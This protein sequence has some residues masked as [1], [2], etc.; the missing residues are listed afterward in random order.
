M[1]DPAY[2]VTGET[3]ITTVDQYTKAERLR[4]DSVF[5]ATCRKGSTSMPLSQVLS[6]AKK[7]EHYLVTGKTA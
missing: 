1:P 5:L 2:S 7:I 4:H 3:K 6:D